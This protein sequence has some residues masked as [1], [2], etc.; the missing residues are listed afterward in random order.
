[1]VRRKTAATKGEIKMGFKNSDHDTVEEITESIVRAQDKAAK[2]L[3]DPGDKLVARSRVA[4]EYRKKHGGK[5]PGGWLPG[6]K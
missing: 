6:D 3:T 1:M 5:L 4:Q 2:G